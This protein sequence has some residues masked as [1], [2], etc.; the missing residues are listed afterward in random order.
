MIII[1]AYKGKFELTASQKSVL[2]AQAKELKM[3]GYSHMYVDVRTLTFSDELACEYVA[4]CN[5]KNGEYTRRAFIGKKGGL[6]HGIGRNNKSGY[7]V[8][9]G[10]SLEYTLLSIDKFEHVVTV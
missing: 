2:F 3:L 1:Q 8:S 4:I 7:G 10:N 6:S 5:N 9:Q